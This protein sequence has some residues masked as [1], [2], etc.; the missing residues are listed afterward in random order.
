[1]AK[2]I[3]VTVL[4]LALVLFPPAVLAVVSNNAVPG[5]AAYPIKRGLE[6]IIF[7]VAS[8]NPTTK[9]WF[10]AARS[11]RRFEEVTALMAQGKKAS[12]TLNELVEQTQAAA[13]QIDQVSDSK[14]KAKLTKQLSDAI[15]KYDTGLSQ[16]SV[17]PPVLSTP[18]VAV[19]AS[20]PLPSFAAAAQPLVTASPQVRSP[21]DRP[22]V[23]S[24]PQPTVIQNSPTP[25][26]TASLLSSPVP[27]SPPK[28]SGNSDI[29]KARD[30][31]KKIKKKLE[32]DNSNQSSNQDQV[33]KKE[34][35]GEK[36]KK[37][38]NSQRGKR[39]N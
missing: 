5:D 30:E 12:K 32:D 33:D 39:N 38:H 34:Q 16:M 9:A 3:G 2:F 20:T 27:V 8:L 11:D 22:Q 10:A 7:A 23:F 21:E 24:T 18:P 13:S 31:L 29:D 19:P 4:I 1:M 35:P 37:D 15:T 25:V 36:D 26:P 28:S 14:E 17:P 6:D